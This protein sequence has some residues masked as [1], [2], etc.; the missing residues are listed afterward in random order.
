MN[1]GLVTAI[2]GLDRASAPSVS[3]TVDVPAFDVD[4]FA[5][6]L[7]DKSTWKPT[8]VEGW[9]GPMRQA[10]DIYIGAGRKKT[11]TRSKHGGQ[12]KHAKFT[13]PDAE[14][15][16]NGAVVGKRNKLARKMLRK[17]V[18]KR[19]S[20]IERRVDNA[21]R[22]IARAE[23]LSDNVH[24]K[25]RVLDEEAAIRTADYNER[26][27][28]WTWFRDWLNAWRDIGSAYGRLTVFARMG[29]K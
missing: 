10:P 5:I 4:L 13:R 17:Q 18:L 21:H 3:V 9:Q 26:L 6:K 24:E 19:R 14:K 7:D 11:K 29:V 20:T 1:A 8:A 28:K 16:A 22:A 12:S 23:H 27:A 25:Q 15:H 2:L